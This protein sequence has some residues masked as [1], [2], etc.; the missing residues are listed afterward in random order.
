[1]DGGADN[2]HLTGGDGRDQFIYRPNGGKDM[3]RDFGTG[4][5]QLNLASFGFTDFAD[6]TASATLSDRTIDFGDGNILK[7]RNIDVTTLSAADV[8]LA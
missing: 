8:I 4:V 2:D 5:D 1:M 6:F 7:L 3:I